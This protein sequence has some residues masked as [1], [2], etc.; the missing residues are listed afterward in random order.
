MH[1]RRK[2]LAALV[3]AAW[4][5]GVAPI[6]AA[7]EPASG[8]AGSEAQV[9]TQG[10]FEQCIAWCRH[11]YAGD[12]LRRERFACFDA[13]ETLDH[14]RAQGEPPQP[15]AS[16]TTAPPG[17]DNPKVQ[18]E[19]EQLVERAEK[20]PIEQL[21]TE[22][23]GIGF[24]PYK[25]STL[26]LT[27]RTAPN[28]TPGSPTLPFTG[29]ALDWKHEEIKFQF[30]LKTLLLSNSIIGRRNSLWFAYTQQSFWQTFDAA[31]SRPFRESDYEPEII[32]SHKLGK[33]DSSPSGLRPLF[34]NLGAVHQSNGRSDPRSRSWNRLYLQLGIEDKL[35]DS[36]SFAVLLRP[37]Y[38][39]HET[40]ATDNNP[41]IEH[42]LGYGDI[43]VDYWRGDGLI[44][45]L[46]RQRSAQLDYSMPLL[47]LN[48]G[49]PKRNSMQLHVQVFSGYGESLLDYNQRHTTIGIGFSVPYGL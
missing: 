31:Q 28:D 16:A 1:V 43:E 41:D 12:K 3:S 45:L 39:L 8:A 20:T 36:Q 21:W 26:M 5:G 35:S 6:A 25:Q 46:A 30:S 9:C 32:F 4:G 7:D 33:V 23:D 44:S 48:D 29:S 22:P 27:Y 47:F 19:A 14:N 24:L 2:M 13:V 17:A 37:W 11:Q 15:P 42:Y 38:R 34:I 18:A 49:K 10:T 40:Y